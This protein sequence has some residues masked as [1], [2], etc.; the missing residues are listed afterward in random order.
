MIPKLY[1]GTAAPQG[2][3]IGLLRDCI[4][5]TVTEERNGS[6]ELELT[7]PITGQHYAALALR[8]LIRAK[9]NPNGNEQD[10]RIYKI[11]RPIGGKVTVNARHISYDLSGVP[12][13]PF[14]AQNAPA[15]LAGL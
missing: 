8:A 7:Y 9:P 1:D 12:V 13:S 14:S 2:N 6:Y 15:A 4:R 3:G 5:C 10:F 11:S